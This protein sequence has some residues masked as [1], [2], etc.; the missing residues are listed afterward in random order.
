[1]REKS[2]RERDDKRAPV[3]GFRLG[4]DATAMRLDQHP[5]D[6]ETETEPR[7]DPRLLSLIEALEEP[8]Q[9]V[10]SNPDTVIF[11]PHLPHVIGRI[12]S[13]G[14]L[15]TLWGILDRVANQVVED[16][17]ES[18]SVPRADDREPWRL[19][20]QCVLRS[21]RPRA[22]ERLV[23]D[24]AEVDRFTPQC[25]P[26]S[27]HPHQLAQIGDQAFHTAR[28]LEDGGDRRFV[29]ALAPLQQLRPGTK[30]GDRGE[31]VVAGHGDEV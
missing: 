16:L 23:H 22:D 11:D 18:G 13:D 29:V 24:L 6:V 27:L 12:D 5:R 3:A 26:A 7:A 1:M 2:P 25:Q 20:A 30:D 4:P 28:L 10:S 8:R 15:A 14:D 17:S 31:K 21:L 19:D 9:D